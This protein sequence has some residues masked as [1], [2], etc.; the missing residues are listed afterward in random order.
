[1]EATSKSPPD[2]E[3]NEGV[4]LW[5]SFLENASTHSDVDRTFNEAKRQLDVLYNVLST[6]SD[7]VTNLKKYA[8]SYSKQ[9]SYVTSCLTNWNESEKSLADP[10]LNE[11]SIPQGSYIM[12]MALI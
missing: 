7:E 10:S 9:M 12:M 6:L 4:A 8:A 3:R 1:M 2:V 11:I 5:Q